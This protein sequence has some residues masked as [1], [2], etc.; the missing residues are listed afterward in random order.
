MAAVDLR[1]G[2]YVLV[3]QGASKGLRPKGLRRRCWLQAPEEHPLGALGSDLYGDES[4]GARRGR[5][6]QR[7]RR[8]VAHATHLIATPAAVPAPR[9]PHHD[10][11]RAQAS[12]TDCACVARAGQ[13]R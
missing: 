3:W 7:P 4:P 10:V 2:R 11:I 1:A 6:K 5:R 13:S 8:G 9:N 12:L